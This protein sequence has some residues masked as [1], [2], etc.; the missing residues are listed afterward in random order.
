MSSYI[1]EI[2]N[3]NYTLAVVVDLDGNGIETT[4]FE[5]IEYIYFDYDGDRFSE[6]TVWINSD[7]A[8]LVM[9]VNNDGIIDKGE[10]LFGSNMICSLL[11]DKF[12]LFHLFT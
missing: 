2:E 1:D 3:N 4:P 7:D 9:D 12:L 11:S 8:F 10:E 6:R 5:N